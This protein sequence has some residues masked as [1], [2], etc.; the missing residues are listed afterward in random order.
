MIEWRDNVKNAILNIPAFSDG[1]QLSGRAV[2]KSRKIASL[3]IHVERAMERL[4]NFK[5]VQ[6]VIK[7]IVEKPSEPSFADMSGFV[8]HARSTGFFILFM[9]FYP[10]TM[11]THAESINSDL[12]RGL[13]RRL[14]HTQHRTQNRTSK[15]LKYQRT[16]NTIAT[17]VVKY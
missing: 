8:K 9:H 7:V 16:T 17:L 13:D 1:K 6:G 5:M 15:P 12:Q 3:R 4:K 11:T 10:G 14:R 2:G